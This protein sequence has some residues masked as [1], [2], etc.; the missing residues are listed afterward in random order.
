MSKSHEHVC[1]LSIA[2]RSDETA[3]ELISISGIESSSNF[4]VLV[5]VRFLP[6]RKLTNDK[7]WI[8]LVGNRHHHL[9]ES[10]QIISISHSLGW[11][12]NVDVS[13]LIVS[14]KQSLYT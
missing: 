1:H 12:R 10:Q 13:A 2:T 6:A 8:K 14:S 3:T 9:L 11:P 4:K 5:V 7:V